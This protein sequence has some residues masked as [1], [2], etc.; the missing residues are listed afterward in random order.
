MYKSD[1]PIEKKSQ[2]LL[3]RSGFSC[4]LA[5]TLLSIKTTDTFTIGLYGKW[6]SGKTSIINMVLEEVERRSQTLPEEKTPIVVRFNPWN[7]SNA[8]QLLQQFF[9]CLH[10]ALEMKKDKGE[11]LEKVGEAIK[12]YAGVLGTASWIPV[13]GKYAKL[14]QFAGKMVGGTLVFLNK[15]AADIS[16]TKKKVSEAL[17][18]KN[19]KL[20]VV[21]D[22][23]DRLSN[24][25]IRM[26]FQL[27]NSL[28]SFPNTI[29]VLSFDYDIVTRALKEVQNCADGGEYLEKIVQ[30]P[31]EIPTA[32]AERIG[33][34]FLNELK[35]VLSEGE[36]Q[37]E[38]EDNEYFMRVFWNVLRLD[39]DSIRSAKRLLNAFRLKQ[40]AMS[41]ELNWI[42]LLAITSLQVFH[43]SI[44]Q[45][46]R[47]NKNR[48]FS[49]NLNFEGM[50]TAEQ[51]KRKDDFLNE[52][53]RV[54]PN[55]AFFML[56]CVNTL[57]PQFARWVGVY[58]EEYDERSLYRTRR[59]S[60]KENFDYF[61]YLALTDIPIG[62]NLLNDVIYAEDEEQ[63][64][65]RIK[66]FSDNGT[67]R[68]FLAHLQ[69]LEKELSQERLVTLLPCILS[70]FGCDGDAV[71][72]KLTSN[73]DDLIRIIGERFLKAINDHEM[74]FK[75]MQ[76][77]IK[78]MSLASLP[79]MAEIVRREEITHGRLGSNIESANRQLLEEKYLRL[80]ENCYAQKIS[81]IVKTQSLLDIDF[82]SPLLL[83]KTFDAEACGEYISAELRKSDLN[84][85]RFVAQYASKW[86]T[87]GA[88]DKVSW[89][90]DHPDYMEYIA[91]EEAEQAIRSCVRNKALFTLPQEMQERLVAFLLYYSPNVKEKDELSS[92]K[93]RKALDYLREGKPIDGINWDE[94]PQ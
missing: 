25:E 89:T 64:R 54:A 75:I 33:Q 84:K 80:V 32:S 22:D 10:T 55:Q 40:G 53:S 91:T 77:A 71:P 36:Y 28:A 3:N 56:N 76:R 27:V 18:E 30:V 47:E 59:I 88:A 69:G 8:E 85:C 6:G 67:I 70:A 19:R 14:V 29:Y 52:F 72:G 87:V 90:Y 24:Q 42:D 74:R 82:R 57:F 60:S 26:I 20:I 93:M 15:G 11:N 66:M 44:Y 35:E 51:K 86:T 23:I 48:I 73:T 16:Q 61:F 58:E 83:W 31:F 62:I 38:F 39:L 68:D 45:W 63:V 17:K 92:K 50:S 41:G 1:E 21:I 43:I 9:A 12:E 78:E 46:I 4:T 34:V 94:M 79:G 49:T 37:K 81:E 65:L 7:Y 2:D 13:G 5:E